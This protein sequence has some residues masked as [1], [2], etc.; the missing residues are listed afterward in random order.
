M[1]SRK[2]AAVAMGILAVVCRACGVFMTLMTVMLCFSG[3]AAKLQIV[4]FI[5][6]LSRALPAAIAGYG[7]ITSPFGGVFRFDY[8]IVA[9][10]FFV[11]DYALTRA[12]RAVR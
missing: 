4:G 3:I 10:V 1:N 5:V 6:E 12:S 9:V 7:V 11:V 2:G 8:A